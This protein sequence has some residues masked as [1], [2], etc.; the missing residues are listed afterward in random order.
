MLRSLI[1]HGDPPVRELR[2]MVHRCL[3]EEAFDVVLFS[4]KR[5]YPALAGVRD[6][7]VDADL[8][9]ATSVRIRVRMRH[10]SIARAL[11]LWAE[12]L[13]VR[14]VERRLMR[15]ARHL[16]FASCRDREALVRNG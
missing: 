2:A 6:V 13:Q 7:P 12:Y 8:C 16:L 4:G 5:T 1:P 11:V 10:S 15:D 3:R 9:D 14:A